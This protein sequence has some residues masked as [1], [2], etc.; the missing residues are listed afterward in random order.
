MLRDDALAEQ[1]ERDYPSAPVDDRRRQML[2]YA[3]KLTGSPADMQKTDVDALRAVGFSDTDI[4]EI[5]EVT[6]YYAYANRI[7]DGLGV[8]LEENSTEESSPE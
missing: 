7:V 4:L 2:A 1:I 5:A 8:A 6:A 3:A